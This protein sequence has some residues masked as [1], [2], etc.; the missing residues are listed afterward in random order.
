MLRETPSPHCFDQL[1]QEAYNYLRYSVFDDFRKINKGQLLHDLDFLEECKKFRSDSS[2]LHPQL[3]FELSHRETLFARRK[4][5]SAEKAIPE[6]TGTSSQAIE[7]LDEFHSDFKK[8]PGTFAGRKSGKDS[9]V[10]IEM[11][12]A[13]KVTGKEIHYDRKVDP[14]VF[15]VI[16]VTMTD[17]IGDICWKVLRRYSDFHDFHMR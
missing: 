14:T 11:T 9:V 5:S 2:S 13:A 3:N 6:T 1:Q 17:G 7:E 8:I 10:S 12:W 15:Y 4:G 16:D